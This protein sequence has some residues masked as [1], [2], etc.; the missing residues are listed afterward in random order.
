LIEVA[1]GVAGVELGG[2]LLVEVA[3]GVR[4]ARVELG[5]AVIAEHRPDACASM[6]A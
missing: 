4:V 3:L 2:V 6:L 5:G 1:L